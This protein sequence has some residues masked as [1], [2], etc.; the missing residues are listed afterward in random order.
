MLKLQTEERVKWRKK[1]EQQKQMD[2]S[3]QRRRFKHEHTPCR[4]VQVRMVNVEV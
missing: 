3:V 1:K 4:E 2:P